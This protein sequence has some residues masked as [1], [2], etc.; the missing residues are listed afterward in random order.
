[1]LP[2][3]NAEPAFLL[4]KIKEHDLSH[5]FLRKIHGTDGFAAELIADT[6][7]LRE[8]TVETFMNRFKQFSILGKKFLS[9]GL[10][11]K[12]I[13][14]VSKC[15]VG[16]GIL[17]QSKKPRLCGVAAFTL[18]YDV[19]EAPCGSDAGFYANVSRLFLHGG[20]FHLYVRKTPSC[21]SG[22]NK[23]YQGSVLL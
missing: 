6:F 9:D 11:A 10:N 15:W 23:S 20:V 3:S 5:Q 16:N 12:S 21:V 14:D 17:E 1:L 22:R 13:L 2:F 8:Q 18:T 19:G 7:V 4:K